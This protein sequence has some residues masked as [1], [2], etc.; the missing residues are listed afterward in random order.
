LGKTTR[1]GKREGTVSPK[2]MI[3]VEDRLATHFQR[4]KIDEKYRNM[5][6]RSKT[7]AFHQK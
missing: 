2:G 5:H 6:T 3:T 7:I 4:I 1:E